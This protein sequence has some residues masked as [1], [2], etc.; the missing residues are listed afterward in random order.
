MVCSVLPP[1][2]VPSASLMVS[3]R[4]TKLRS[5]SH[6]TWLL[7]GILIKKVSELGDHSSFTQILEGR[8]RR[9]TLFF[10]LSLSSHSHQEH[11][12]TLQSSL[13]LQVEAS[14]RP[15]QEDA[16]LSTFPPRERALIPH[17]AQPYSQ[18]GQGWEAQGQICTALRLS[19]A[20][21]VK[22]S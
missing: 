15:K 11:K 6:F 1:D 22:I 7:W 20:L 14:T 19:D 5:S 2:T 3:L 9:K 8:A 18:G 13:L 16:E 17:S 12:L 21:G 10:S 4:E